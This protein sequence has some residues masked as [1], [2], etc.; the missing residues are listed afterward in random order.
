[1]NYQMPDGMI[2]LRRTAR[3][4]FLTNPLISLVFFSQIQAGFALF[5]TN[6]IISAAVPSGFI[7]SPR[8]CIILGYGMPLQLI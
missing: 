1:M 4:H 8:K 3:S 2:K 5:Y 7:I 6:F